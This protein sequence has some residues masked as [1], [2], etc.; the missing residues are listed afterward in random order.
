M[1]LLDDLS[2]RVEEL[3]KKEAQTA[4]EREILEAEI[5]Q[6][7]DAAAKA[8]AQTAPQRRLAMSKRIASAT[9]VTAVACAIVLAIYPR[10]NA[11]EKTRYYIDAVFDWARSCYAQSDLK[12]N[13]LRAREK[14]GEKIYQ[15]DLPADCNIHYKELLAALKTHVDAA[16]CMSDAQ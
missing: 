12:L 9:G 1:S 6:L 5:Q 14:Q 4:S 7:K 2:A 8:E 16:P 10:P 11:C 3:R 15:E 13:E